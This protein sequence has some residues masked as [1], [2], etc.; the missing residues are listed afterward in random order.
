MKCVYN[1]CLQRNCVFVS[2][3]VPLIC[4]QSIGIDNRYQSITTWIFAIDWSSIININR[5]IDIDWYRLISIVID[6]RFH[7]L[8]T[9]GEYKSTRSKT[10]RESLWQLTDFSEVT[11]HRLACMY[12]NS[13]IWQPFGLPSKEFNVVFLLSAQVKP[14][15]FPVAFSFCQPSFFCQFRS[16]YDLCYYMLR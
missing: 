11:W 1:Y 16:Y 13:Q 8:D 6:Y 5:S 14:R 4:N 10:S 3:P 2:I 9:P 15:G 12:K 7:R